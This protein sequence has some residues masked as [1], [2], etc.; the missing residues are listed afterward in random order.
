[1]GRNVVWRET[2]HIHEDNTRY[3]T[4]RYVHIP[5]QTLYT[6]V[7]AHRDARW[8]PS[9]IGAEHGR[10][11]LVW[12]SA[13][14]TLPDPVVVLV[15][16]WAPANAIPTTRNL[17]G[18]HFLD[19]V[20][21]G[22]RAF[23]AFGDCWQAAAIFASTARC[24]QGVRLVKPWSFRGLIYALRERIWEYDPRLLHR[25]RGLAG[26]LAPLDYRGLIIPNASLNSTGQRSLWSF[27][28]SHCSFRSITLRWMN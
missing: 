15:T 16:E 11:V 19:T 3:R 13:E 25:P 2:R 18:S 12:G 7:P 8:G 26:S 9:L 6:L 27:R 22:A 4:L 24:V 23:I 28:R 20:E 10:G 14:D 17:M 21:P 5:S 1:M